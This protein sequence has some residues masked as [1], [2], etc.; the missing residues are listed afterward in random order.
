MIN[1]SN[2]HG[3]DGSFLGF[4]FQI[5]RAL[6]WLSSSQ[7]DAVVG[8]EVDEDI[9]VRLTDG[10]E[11]HSIYEQAKHSISKKIPFSDKSEDLWKTLAIW[12]E[13]TSTGRFNIKNSTL[14]FLTNRK[15]PSSRLVYTLHNEKL[16]NLSNTN[17]KNESIINL[18]KRLKIE[19][20]KLPKALKPYR[21]IIEECPND[22]LVS[23]IDRITVLDNAVVHERNS[24]KK[25][26]KGNLHISDDIPFDSVYNGLFGY[27]ADTL[28]MLWR[29]RKAGWISVKAFN[30]QYIQLVTDFKRKSF[31]EKTVDSLPVGLSD[32]SKNRGKV[33]VE[34]LNLIGGDEEEIIDAIH[35]YVRAASE[36]S[37]LAQDGE[38]SESK[39]R[40]YFDDLLNHWKSISKPKFKYCGPSDYTKIGYEVYYKS[41]LYKGKLNN[42]EPEQG[43]TH[44]GSYH[45]LADQVQLGWHP[46]WETLKKKK[47]D[48]G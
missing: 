36:R 28:I 47:D 48:E 11:I 25:T 1:V 45:Y 46:K 14:S 10:E 15:M 8:I 6:L 4:L 31:I 19:A 12:V 34:Q 17:H 44:R 29:E 37:R 40:N 41:L 16:T 32:I 2:L 43:Y 9:T 21:E 5:E 20:G 3:A 42:Y 18:A 30:Q 33:F 26:L 23:I 39:F 38:I 13:A 27:V 22:V 35:D 24:L 7:E